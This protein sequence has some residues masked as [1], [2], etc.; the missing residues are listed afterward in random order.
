[1]R[2]SLS[3][4]GAP[5]IEQPTRAGKFSFPI[6]PRDWFAIDLPENGI[7]EA[8]RGSFGRF[9]EFHGLMN[10][11]MGGETLEVSQLENGHSERLLDFAVELANGLA[12]VVLDQVIE[13]GPE[14]ERSEND[15]ACQTGVPRLQ[16]L[17]SGS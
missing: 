15:L 8:A 13:L 10:H 1:L 3:E 2:Q 11:G 6:R 12:G 9:H 5:A 7:G 4:L 16:M 14:P 17:R